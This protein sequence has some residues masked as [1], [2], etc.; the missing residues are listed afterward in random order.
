MWITR[1]GKAQFCI[2]WDTWVPEV[3]II[4]WQNTPD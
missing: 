1:I 4:A 3:S 2:S